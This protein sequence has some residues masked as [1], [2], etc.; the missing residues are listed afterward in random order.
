MKKDHMRN[1]TYDSIFGIYYSSAGV[2]QNGN[3]ILLSRVEEDDIWVLPEGGVKLYETTEEALEREIL[4]EM[5][6]EIEVERLL[7]IVE[8]IFDVEE[9]DMTPE[10]PPGKYHDIHFTFL[11]KPKEKDGDWLKEEFYGMEDDFI[12][13]TRLKLVFRWFAPDELDDINLVPV[14]MKQILK[15]IPDH[16]TVVVN[17]EE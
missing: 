3:R 5:G 11:I 1:V 16:P 13:D 2:M 17:R 8:N 12:P 9:S 15:K 6:F 14:C 7:W 10:F 4:E